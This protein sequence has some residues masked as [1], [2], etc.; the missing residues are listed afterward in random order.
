MSAVGAV[1]GLFRGAL[2]GVIFAGV[3][4]FIY[5]KAPSMQSSSAICSMGINPI[6]A[7]CLILAGVPVYRG[8]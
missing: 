2:F 4:V 8:V 1:S 7:T 6:L 3:S 5:T